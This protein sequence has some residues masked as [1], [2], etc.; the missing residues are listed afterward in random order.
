MTLTASLLLDLV[1]LVI[2][3]LFFVQGIRRGFVL[4][5][6]SLLAVILAL[7]GGWYLAQHY[8]QPVQAALEPMI[9]ERMLPNADSGASDQSDQSLAEEVQSQVDEAAQTVQNAILTQQA[10]V[11]AGMAAR[12]LLFLAGFIIVLLVWVI[13]CHALDLVAKLPGLNL[14][15]KVL[16]GVLGLVKGLILLM[17]LRWL[18]C[19]VFRLIPE[20][21]A[22]GSYVLTFLSS[23]PALPS[24]G[25]LFRLG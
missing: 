24:L 10:K 4:T 19:D 21:V 13:L 7:I 2:L 25:T 20:E 22:A 6:C 9:L 16:G 23:F 8:A 12:V 3:V 18:L 11:V 14:V 1:L 5:L 17:V 15:N